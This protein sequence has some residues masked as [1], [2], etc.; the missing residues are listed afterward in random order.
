MRVNHISNISCLQH[1]SPPSCMAYFDT[2]A[3]RSDGIPMRSLQ[4]R[5]AELIFF[6]WAMSFR[7][8]LVMVHKAYC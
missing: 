8:P 4:D 6:L 5:P 3:Y 2:L 7:G 1:T